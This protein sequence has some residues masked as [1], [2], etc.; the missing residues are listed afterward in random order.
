MSPLRNRKE[1]AQVILIL[2]WIAATFALLEIT[3]AYR[4]AF[5]GIAIINFAISG[6]FF[7]MDFK[8]G[9]SHD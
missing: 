4:Y 5:I 7:W 1:Q 3:S 6:Y 9:K 8:G 2:A